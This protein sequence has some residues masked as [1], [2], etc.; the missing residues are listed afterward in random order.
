MSPCA[1]AL[2]VRYLHGRI[3]IIVRTSSSIF[4]ARPWCQQNHDKYGEKTANKMEKD[5][6][7]NEMKGKS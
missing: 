3:K 2:G 6:E 1:D 4:Q 7:R 5:G